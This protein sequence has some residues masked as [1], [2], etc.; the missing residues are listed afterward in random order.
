MYT[1]STSSTLIIKQSRRSTI[2]A[3]DRALFRSEIEIAAIDNVGPPAGI[4]ISTITACA[5][6]SG[7]PKID[8]RGLHEYVTAN[9]P[10][11][12]KSAIIIGSKIGG[13]AGQCSLRVQIN[14][15]RVVNVKVFHNA[16][17]QCTGI[18]KPIVG[19]HALRAIK[20]LIGM[21]ED[22]LPAQFKASS[23]RIEDYRTVNINST[24]K[25]HNNIRQPELFKILTRT[26]KLFVMFDT[27]HYPGV[28]M[29]YFHNAKNSVQ[30]GRCQCT[31]PCRG[32]G[33]GDI[34]G[35]CRR[36]TVSIFRSGI[37]LITGSRNYQQLSDVYEFI[38]NIFTKHA[39]EITAPI[40]SLKPTD[41][42][43]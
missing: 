39:T 17:L 5:R 2:S 21:T 18:N 19:I 14:P 42:T 10:I 30:N 11:T 20:D 29:K 22:I 25:W 31:E 35:F 34:R 32:K 36:V 7:S 28:N 6:F 41:T 9:A 12:I 26:Y 1:N 38:R 40:F 8:F 43:E 15:S 13:F 23:L 37:V 24:Y 4:V 27:T 16:S 3:V 33:D